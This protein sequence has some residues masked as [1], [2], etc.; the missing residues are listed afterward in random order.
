MMPTLG[1]CHAEESKAPRQLSWRPEDES[2]THFAVTSEGE[3]AS[4]DPK[5][6]YTGAPLS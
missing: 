5:G 4:L 1:R 2:A 3:W 6:C